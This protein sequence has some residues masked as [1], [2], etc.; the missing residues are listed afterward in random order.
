MKTWLPACV[1]VGLFGALGL[2]CGGDDDADLE[3]RICRKADECNVLEVSFQD[4]SDEI[5]MCTDELVSSERSD[6]NVQIEDC[7]QLSNCNNFAA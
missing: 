7:L 6:W 4:C 2:G 3:D 1:L 5:H